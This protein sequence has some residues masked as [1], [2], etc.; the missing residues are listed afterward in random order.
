MSANVSIDT[1]A[2]RGFGVFA[3]LFGTANAA[4]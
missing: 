3:G 2:S 1:G 4:E